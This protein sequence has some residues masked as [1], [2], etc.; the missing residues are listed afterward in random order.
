M[1]SHAP[2]AWLS[3]TEA[4]ARRKSRHRLASRGDPERKNTPCIFVLAGGMHFEIRKGCFSFG[5]LPSKYSGSVAG[6][7]FGLGFAKTIFWGYGFSQN[8]DK[9]VF[10]FCPRGGRSA[11][12]KSQL[13]HLWIVDG[14]VFQHHPN[15]VHH[16]STETD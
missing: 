15:N 12:R 7:Q 3:E 1:N 14:F 6:L 16:L 11:M 4:Y 13:I 9:F 8:R 10:G 2:R 5:V